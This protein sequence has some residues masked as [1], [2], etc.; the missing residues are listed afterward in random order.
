MR[1]W[2][3]KDIMEIALSIVSGVS[4]SLLCMKVFGL[5]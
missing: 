5:I 4:G 2:T 3:K 1:K